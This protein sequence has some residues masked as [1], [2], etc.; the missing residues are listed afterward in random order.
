M[1]KKVQSYNMLEPSA[2]VID[3]LFCKNT[4]FTKS[5]PEP[6]TSYRRWQN[7]CNF[8]LTWKPATPSLQPIF[9]K[10]AYPSLPGSEGGV[11]RPSPLKTRARGDLSQL[12]GIP[13]KNELRG[14]SPATMNAQPSRTRVCAC[15]RS[16][17]TPLPY[18][19]RQKRSIAWQLHRNTSTTS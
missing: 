16:N 11:T 7:M 10:V 8:G 15:S 2:R 12:A 1:G 6:A 9:A 17:Q 18:R 5:L 19:D 3:Y 13:P 4:K 14:Q